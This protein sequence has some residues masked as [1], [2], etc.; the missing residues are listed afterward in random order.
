MKMHQSVQ[1]YSHLYSYKS[2]PQCFHY[3]IAEF[4]FEPLEVL[5]VGHVRMA[6]VGEDHERDLFLLVCPSAY[7]SGTI[8]TEAHAHLGAGAGCIE[9][10]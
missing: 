7:T 3:C 8:V 5:V 1:C 9:P 4:G 2:V 6:S 10:V